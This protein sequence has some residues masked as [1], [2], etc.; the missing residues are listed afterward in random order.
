MIHG[1]VCPAYEFVAGNIHAGAENG[2][3]GTGGHVKFQVAVGDLVLGDAPADGIGQG[4]GVLRT[5]FGQNHQE[6]LAAI[7]GDNV[8]GAKPIREPLSHVFQTHVAHVMAVGVVDRLEPVQIQ[9]DHGERAAAAPAP[10]DL[11]FEQEVGLAAVEQACQIVG[12]SHAC[13]GRVGFLQFGLGVLE[14]CLHLTLLG[15]VAAEPN[16]V[17]RPAGGIARRV[18]RPGN[19]APFSRLGDNRTVMLASEAFRAVSDLIEQFAD[20]RAVVG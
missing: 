19:E 5:G 17:A 10:G 18:V 11:A 8:A 6:L 12:R 2:D 13:Q 4:E 7:P 15:N 14:A 1:L 20:P 16:A 3:A 9:K